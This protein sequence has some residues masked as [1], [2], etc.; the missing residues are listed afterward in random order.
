MKNQPIKAMISPKIN[1]PELEYFLSDSSH[2]YKKVE[3]AEVYELVKEVTDKVDP[4]YKDKYDTK[5]EDFYLPIKRRGRDIVIPFSIVLYNNEFYVNFY[6]IGGLHIINGDKKGDK[7]FKQIFREELKFIKN[8]A[9]SDEFIE[10]KAPYDF[11][12]G[13]IKGKYILNKIMPQRE[14]EKILRIYKQNLN[15]GIQRPEISLNDYL[16]TAGICYKAAYGKKTKGLTFLEMY[17]KWADNRDG[18][19]LS[20]KD[21]GSKIEFMNWHKSGKWTGSHPFEIVFSWHRH[22]IHL[23]PPGEY[24]SWRYCL[25]VTNYAYAGN[26]I[27][28]TTALIKKETPFTAYNLEEVLNY[29]TGESYFTVNDYSDN[30]FLYT[31]S[32]ENKKNYFRYIEWD[33]LKILMLLK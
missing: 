19:M 28:M 24:N 3:D 16:E 32:K 18:G 26:F 13:K 15:K 29:L 23:H 33:K 8:K 5:W 2:N 14:S 22:G 30:Y 1:L 27:K 12:I 21:R 7:I 9:F 6:N 17:K 10:K 31:P 11:R 4:S 25:D 20:I